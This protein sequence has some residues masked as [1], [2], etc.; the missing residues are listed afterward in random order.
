MSDSSDTKVC[1]MC[2]ETIRRTAIVCPHCRHVQGKWWSLRNP[3]VIATIAGIFWFCVL[4]ALAFL[5]ERAFDGRAF[6]PHRAEFSILE[7]S[8]S[9]RITSNAVYV[10][11]IG[12]LTNESNFSWKQIGIEAQLFNREGKL[13][14][15]IPAPSDYGGISVARHETAAFKLEGKTG[16]Q[17]SDY[18]SHKVFVRWGKDA[19][20]WP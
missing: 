6:E 1:P 9:Q 17:L 7:S 13:I 11:V 16:N 3:S 15:V 2:V 8:V 12:V 10:V 4:F 18:A 19:T 20:V 5:V 14:D